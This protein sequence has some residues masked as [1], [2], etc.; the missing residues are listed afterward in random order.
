MGTLSGSPVKT[1]YKKLAWYDSSSGNLNYTN[2]S[3]VDTQISNIKISGSMYIPAAQKLYLD[4]GTHTYFHESSNDVVQLAGGVDQTAAVRLINMTP[5]S[6]AGAGN[7]VYGLDA[8]SNLDSASID[9]T[10]FGYLAG[11]ATHSNAD[12][13]TGI[14][15]KTL[16]TLTT[17]NGNVA[18]GNDSMFSAT[19][20]LYNTALGTNSL[21]ADTKG[22]K[23]V[24][25]GYN[26]L[27]A[28][29]FDGS[30]DSSN[31][32]SRNVAVGFGAGAAI[33]YG[34]QNVLIGY[35]AGDNITTGKQNI[36]IGHAAEIS[37]VGTD[38]EIVIGAD[39]TGL[40]A[41][42]IIIGNTSHTDMW[43][44]DQF[45][46]DIAN[47][48]FVMHDD[49]DTADM[50]KI[51]IGASGA[52][53]LSTIDD[54]AAVGHLSIDPDGNTIFPNLTSSKKVQFKEASTDHSL[55]IYHNADDVIFSHPDNHA[56][57][58]AGASKFFEI[59]YDGSL[60]E[61]VLGQSYS[62][63][64]H[65]GSNDYFAIQLHTDGQTDLVTANGGVDTNADLNIIADGEM[66]LQTATD[67]HIKLGSGT[68]FD[69]SSYDD[70]A[71]VTVDFR[72][73]NKAHLDMTGGSISGT[74]TLQF[75]A[76]SGNFVLVVQQDGSAR[77]IAAYAT[78]DAAG[79]AGNNDGGTGGAIRWQ[80]GS[81]PDLTDGGNKRD[82]LS[83]YWDATEEVCYGVASLNF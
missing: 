19:E 18:I 4:G 83:F 46:F 39:A 28:Q 56:V 7:T 38:N 64:F 24:A 32:E 36:V 58:N 51:T 1:I 23:S 63:Q 20:A 9:N 47:T 67:H 31:V 81:V 73:S 52:T 72:D 50:F 15:T 70:A 80:G 25:L 45:N 71:D 43:I 42:N 35:L 53:T 27:T 37:A 33:T 75:P 79:N 22:T 34:K 41:N 13:N 12:G 40:G 57:F 62:H 16:T 76:V 68:G 17:G 74:L 60:R 49:T 21:D 55:D 6:G 30:V 3:D 54:G 61:R 8:G 78:K 14:G 11:D 65:Y 82:I 2:D 5:K 66:S 10:Y 29:N 59:W 69:R 44:S 77:T 26:A 48:E